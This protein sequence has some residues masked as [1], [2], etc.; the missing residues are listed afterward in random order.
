MTLAEV[1]DALTQDPRYQAFLASMFTPVAGASGALRYGFVDAS[2]VTRLFDS[3]QVGSGVMLASWLRSYYPGVIQAI[4]DAAP[5]GYGVAMKVYADRPPADV[6]VGGVYYADTRGVPWWVLAIQ[7]AIPI[8]VAALGTH[9]A[10]SAAGAA[11]SGGSAAITAGSSA[12]A[13][14]ATTAAV[15]GGVA[16]AGSLVSTIPSWLGVFTPQPSPVSQTL[17]PDPTVAL[18]S[19]LT[20]ES[21]WMLA[22]VA[23]VL[24]LV[25]S[26]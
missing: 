15:T 22:A 12:A 10:G 9:I 6:P 26:R 24:I 18:A 3:R 8:G 13:A 7:I 4:D 20:T 19:P 11:A 2:G 21:P 17:A 1:N 16:A 23:G 25:V 14:T 5:S